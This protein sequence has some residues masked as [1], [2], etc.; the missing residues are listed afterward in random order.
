MENTRWKKDTT[1]Y[2]IFACFNCRNYLLVKTT[3]KGKKCLRCGKYH[4]VLDLDHVSEVVKG[5]TAAKDRLI[6]LQNKLAIKELGEEPDF[7]AESE[8]IV[9]TPKKKVRDFQS[10][11]KTTNE[12]DIFKR[13]L[14]ELDRKFKLFPGYLIEMMAEERKISNIKCESLIKKCMNG[15]LLVRKDNG[16]YQLLTN[17]F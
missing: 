12:F 11:G 3:Q 7:H 10:K 14:L 1:S 4:R 15:K 16:Y 13:I 17:D 6:T 9:N 5:M 2:Y 8:L